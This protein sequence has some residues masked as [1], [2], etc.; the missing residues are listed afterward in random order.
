MDKDYHVGHS[1][2]LL[3]FFFIPIIVENVPTVV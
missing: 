1:K 3:L 2:L